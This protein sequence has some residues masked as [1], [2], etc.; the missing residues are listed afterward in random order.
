MNGD[1]KIHRF[2]LQAGTGKLAV[3]VAVNTGRLPLTREKR[4]LPVRVGSPLSHMGNN[5]CPL[6]NYEVNMFAYPYS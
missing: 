6:L 3:H 1:L 4:L 5:G 2:Q